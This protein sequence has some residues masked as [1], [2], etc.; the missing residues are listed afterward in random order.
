MPYPTN[1]LSQL[2]SPIL[3]PTARLIVGLVAVPILRYVRTRFRPNQDWDE[4]FERDLEQWTRAS[5]VLLL[6]TKN[7]EGYLSLWF[8]EKRIEIDLDSNWYFAAGRLLL[9]IGVIESMPD[10]QLFSIIHPGPKKLRWIPRVG[11]VENIRQQAGPLARGLL[12]M[13]LSR[14]SPVF[15][16]LAV[17][18]SG[19]SGW[20]FFL[21]AITQYLIIGLV[22]SRDKAVDALSRFDREIAQRREALIEEFKLNSNERPSSPPSPP[23]PETLPSPESAASEQE[24]ATG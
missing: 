13:H 17:I 15:A 1:W 2:L 4:E 21:I 3:K 11:L 24:T 9:A 23:V 8:S 18:F 22:T 19:R 20:I 5:L 12:C 6:A 14:S 10:Q 16:I 7:V